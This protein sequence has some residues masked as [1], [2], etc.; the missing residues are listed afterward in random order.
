M[1]VFIIALMME[2]VCTS[3]TSV[4]FSE[5]T[6]R[7]IPK[8][9]HLHTRRRESVKSQKVR[10]CSDLWVTQTK[11]A[12]QVD[13]LETNT[14]IQYDTG[15]GKRYTTYTRVGWVVRVEYHI[16]TWTGKCF[17]WEKVQYIKKLSTAIWSCYELRLI[18]VSLK[19]C[20]HPHVNIPISVDWLV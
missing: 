8:D 13:S 12:F 15:V 16:P 14:Q 20:Q 7:H 1:R 2:A 19:H 10:V 6:W 4:Y 5:T 9:S 17:K 11:L 3:E 18:S